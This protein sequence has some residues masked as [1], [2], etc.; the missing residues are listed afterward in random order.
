MNILM[1]GGTGLLGQQ[2]TRSLIE[3][4]HDVTI[5]TRNPDKST[6]LPA[7][8]RLVWWDAASTENWSDEMEAADV[9]VHLAGENLAEGRWTDERKR[10]IR[11]SRV[12]SGQA[13]A[14]AIKQSQNPPAAFIQASAVGYYGPRKDGV[15]DESTGPG[16]DFLAHVCFEWE[17]ATASVERMGV[18]RAIARTGI[19]LSQ[20]EGAL[21][22]MLLPFKLYVGGKVGDGK[23]WWPW[24]HVEDEIRALRFLIEHDDASGPF[25][26]TAPN[27]VTNQEFAKTLGSVMGKPS[28]LPVPSAALSL[29]FGEMSTVL[30]DGQ[31]AVPSRLMECGFEF[32]YPNLEDALKDLLS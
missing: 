6:S 20:D 12:R 14:S 3:D 28:L 15:I 2:L 19:V 32:K 8:A 26:L 24:I 1:S 29:A 11:E 17:A 22:R 13:L 25:N 4:G 9:V 30:L 16:S 18:R 31:R 10:R 27:P 5:L 21:P 23:Q 7:S